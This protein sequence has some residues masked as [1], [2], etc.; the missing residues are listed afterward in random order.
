MSNK[1]TCPSCGIEIEISEAIGEE[2]KKTVLVEEH[3]KHD[4]EIRKLKEIQSQ[5]LA[6]LADKSKKEALEKIKIEFENRLKITNDEAEARKKQN[7]EL[8]MQIADI[9]KQLREA[10][11]AEGNI[12]LKYEKQMFEEQD[13]IKQLAKK[14]AQEE[15]GLSRAQDRKKMD[16][17][18]EQLRDAQRKIQQGSQQLQ[19]EVQELQLENMLKEAFIYDEIQEVPKGINGADVIQLVRNNSGMACGTIVWESKNT[20]NWSQPWIAKL[21][22]DTRTLKA[23]VSILVSPVLPEGITTFGEVEGVWVCTMPN[24]IPLAL[25]MRQKIIE[26][27]N[28]LEINKGKETKAEVVFNYITSNDFKQRIEV[29]IDYFKTRR[30]DM[31][32]EK[33]YF[34]KKWDKEDKSIMKVLQNTAGMYGDLQGMMGT[35]LP[36]VQYLE[37][38]GPDEAEPKQTPLEL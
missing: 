28:T 3:A 27:R 19:G 30:E 33:A 21:K 31:D 7:M 38:E 24:A 13:R 1:I 20:K 36:K 8:Q 5:E 6:N 29:W 16:D 18:E 12:K 22:E 2:L 14:E 32:K 11:D 37:L 34:M 23:N 26:V 4:A 25:A 10:K 17:L 15:Y 35:A 9:L